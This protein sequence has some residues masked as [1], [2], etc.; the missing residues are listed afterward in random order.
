MILKKF[1][2]L[3]YQIIFLQ[4]L[5]WHLLSIY[6]AINYCC[7]EEI[8]MDFYNLDVGISVW[9]HNIYRPNIINI[10]INEIFTINLL[11]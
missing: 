2:V 11:I 7:C 3:Q 9:H 6:I 5:I 8:S 1:A 4:Q 10:V